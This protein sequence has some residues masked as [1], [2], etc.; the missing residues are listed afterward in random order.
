[1]FAK[2]GEAIRLNRRAFVVNDCL[3]DNNVMAVKAFDAVSDRY[4]YR[5]IQLQDFS[6]LARS[7]TV[8]SLRKG[9]IEGIHFPLAPTNEQTRIADKL[10]A[11]LARVDACRDRL[12]RIPA[13]LKRLRQSVLSTATSGKLLEA[14][15]SKSGARSSWSVGKLSDLL[16]GKPRNGYSPRAVEKV[17]SVKSLSLSATTSGVFRPEYFKYIDEVISPDSHLWLEPG[18]I[19]I[20]RANTLEYVGTSAMY[21]GPA[22]TF[23]YPDLMMK[24]RANGATLP[25]FLLLILKSDRVREHFRSNA[26]GTARNM[27]KINQQTVLSAPACWPSLTEQAEIVRRVESLFALADRVE[28]RYAATRAQLEKLTPA[29]LAK[30]FR[31]ELVPQDPND[32]PAEVLLKRIR[33]KRGG[34]GADNSKRARNRKSPQASAQEE[35]PC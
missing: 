33:A 9:D 7:T 27:P 29:T 4:L 35:I 13:I 31:G 19:L 30:A 25:R 23:I 34:S 15:K 1:M 22:S 24:A 16:I 21:Q 11:V 6:T 3:I 8:P 14:W 26:T 5:F 12:D 18:D 32:E 28:A 17:T 2:I 10:D 20:Q